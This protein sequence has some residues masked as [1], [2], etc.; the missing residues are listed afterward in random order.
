MKL[1]FV[2]VVAMSSLFHKHMFKNFQATCELA[3]IAIL[4]QHDF[5]FSNVA[6]KLILVRDLMSCKLMYINQHIASRWRK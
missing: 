4:G 2:V 3:R 5:S 6:A 1:K